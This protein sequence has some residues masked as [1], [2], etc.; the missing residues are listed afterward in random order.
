MEHLR[1]FIFEN[2][3]K[4][5]NSDYVKIK[6]LKD[7]DIEITERTKTHIKIVFYFMVIDEND[8]CRRITESLE[9]FLD[10]QHHYYRN[11]H[12]PYSSVPIIFDIKLPE[13]REVIINL[14]K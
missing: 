4:I 6:E 9:S 10:H 3:D 13:L 2:K 7:I 14:M 11:S 5:F 12:H 8:N 1:N